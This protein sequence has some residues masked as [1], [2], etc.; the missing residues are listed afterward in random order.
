MKHSFIL[1]VF[2]NCSLSQTCKIDALSY[3]YLIFFFY[4]L[5]DRSFTYL[6]VINSDPLA[7]YTIYVLMGK[8]D[9]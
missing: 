3:G 4:K 2:L 9:F 5:H 1:Y 6:Y 7:E 8:K